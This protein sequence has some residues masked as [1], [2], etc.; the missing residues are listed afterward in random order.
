M[1]F[2]A[3]SLSSWPQR[4]LGGIVNEKAK[5]QWIRGCEPGMEVGEEEEEDI[6]ADEN[7]IS[8]D[9]EDWEKQSNMA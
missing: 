5:V 6:F 7:K 8:N 1:D 4:D 3:T 9:E 2:P